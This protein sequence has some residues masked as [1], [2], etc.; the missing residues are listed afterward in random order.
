VE[1]AAGAELLTTFC[2]SCYLHLR[3]L[4]GEDL[5]VRDVTMLL[6]EEAER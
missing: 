6:A 2:P 1:V 3:T 4:A 5:I